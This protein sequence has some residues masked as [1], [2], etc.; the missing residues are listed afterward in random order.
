[1][2]LDSDA[3]SHSKS[4]RET[5]DS[6]SP[7]RVS[8]TCE[9]ELGYLTFDDATSISYESCASEETI[10]PPRTR[11]RRSP[12]IVRDQL[13]EE[14]SR[15][16]SPRSYHLPKENHDEERSSEYEQEHRGRDV[17]TI[18]SSS[19]RRLARKHSRHSL[20][21]PRFRS[22]SIE[23]YRRICGDGD[24]DEDQDGTTHHVEE[25]HND[26]SEEDDDSSSSSSPVE[27]DTDREIPDIPERPPSR[28]GFFN[29]DDD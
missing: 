19:C 5:K 14:H 28:L 24:E 21:L 20:H 29:D 4:R 16:S 13:C 3:I 25:V 17:S 6:R 9:D 11:R 10:R 12:S 26:S 2:T 7:S 1:M 8:R 18:R 15:P 22:V 27:S 23:R